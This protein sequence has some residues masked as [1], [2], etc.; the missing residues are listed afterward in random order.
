MSFSLFPGAV[1]D[2]LAEFDDPALAVLKAV[3]KVPLVGV[4]VGVLHLAHPLSLTVFESAFILEPRV[5]ALLSVHVYQELHKVF[6]GACR[7]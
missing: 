1:V 6:L 7:G 5:S 4:A 2:K 3:L